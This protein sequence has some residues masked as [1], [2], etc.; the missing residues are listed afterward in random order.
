[1]SVYEFC[2]PVLYAC[3]A[4]IGR[5]VMQ[6]KLHSERTKEGNEGLKQQGSSIYYSTVEVTYIVD[7]AG[8]SKGPKI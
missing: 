2:A 5:Q 4:F 3:L 1:M 6:A 8:P 7:N